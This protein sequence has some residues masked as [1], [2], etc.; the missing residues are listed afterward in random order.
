MEGASPADM[1]EI[2]R[3]L[4]PT[5]PLRRTNASTAELGRVAKLIAS[6]PPR[7]TCPSRALGPEL[8]T[9]LRLSRNELLRE[10]P[11]VLRVLRNQTAW[12]EDEAALLHG[13]RR[14]RYCGEH[15][16]LVDALIP[17]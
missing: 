9:H 7:P 16:V 4:E 6:P 11:H 17:P 12:F 13:E 15:Q 14:R 1:L 10:M 5:A 2:R 3:L 8:H